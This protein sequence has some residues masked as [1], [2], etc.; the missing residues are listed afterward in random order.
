M[1]LVLLFRKVNHT[2]IWLKTIATDPNFDMPTDRITQVP[3]F[4]RKFDVNFPPRSD[5]IN[6]ILSPEHGAVWHTD[7]SLIENSAGAGIF[8]E[9][10]YTEISTPLSTYCS[11]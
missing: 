8:C 3:K 5:G 10:P 4:D 2:F 7:G 1:S 9:N 11:I 6:G